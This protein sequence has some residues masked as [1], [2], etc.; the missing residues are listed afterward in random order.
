MKAFRLFL[1]GLLLVLTACIDYT[2]KPRGWLRIDP[3]SPASYLPLD[4]APLPYTF[5]RAAQSIVL[6][7]A[8]SGLQQGVTL[9]Y[10]AWGA[11]I[12]GSCLPVNRQQV[13]QAVAEGRRLLLRQLPYG[14]R[15]EEKSYTHA[16]A[17]VYGSLFFVD[18]DA[19][20]PIQFLL[21]DSD[22][23]LFRGALYYDCRPDADSLAPVTGYLRTDII[24][25]IE[26]F[27]WR[28]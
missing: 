4:T 18:G 17:K 25:L 6:L 20:S 19:A 14:A 10:P 5:R 24:E 11:T 26:S 23:Y 3:P 16:E 7:P 13:G 8:D 21:T 1:M 2:P 22:R 9:S 27:R 28:D 15:V 12:Y